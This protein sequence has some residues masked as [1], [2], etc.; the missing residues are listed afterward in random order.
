MKPS[1]LLPD[2]VF[3][4]PTEELEAFLAT[5]EVRQLQQQAAM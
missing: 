3:P 4:L 2:L 5:A 1:G